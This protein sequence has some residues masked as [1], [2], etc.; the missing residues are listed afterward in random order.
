MPRP[1]QAVRRPAWAGLTPQQILG[2]FTPGQCEP[3]R[4]LEVLIELYN[5]Q[6][7][8]LAKTVS[9]K[10]RQERAQFL[11]RF[12]RDLK[13]KAGFSTAPDPRCLRQKHLHAMIKVWQHEALAPATVQTYLSFLRGLAQWIGKPG[14]VRS[15]AFYGMPE[16]DYQRHENALHDHSWAAQDVVAHEV[17]EQVRAFDGY[18]GASLGLILAFGL[19]RKESVLCRPY[20]HLQEHETLGPCLRVTGK[21]GR[22]RWIPVDSAERHQALRMAQQ[23]VAHADAPLGDPAHDLRHNLRRFD[24]V[25]RKFG[26]T[27]AGLGVT[28]HGL[29]HQVL[30]ER[31]TALTGVAPPVRTDKVVVNQ[32]A[33]RAARR[34]VAELA[35]HARPRASG[36]YLGGTAS[37]KRPPPEEP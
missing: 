6:H 5:T 31:Y 24:Y 1:Q 11:R 34:T 35:G 18:V 25:L 33:D 36:A 9:Y 28:A 15:P 21:G 4:V 3:L 30:I 20:T 12:F 22:V 10:T 8:A 23:M 17:I 29:R 19:R 14:L 13:A 26:V 32:A 2:R 7:T 27:H 37:R 16:A